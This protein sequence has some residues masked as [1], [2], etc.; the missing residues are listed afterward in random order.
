MLQVPFR[1]FITATF[2]GIIPASFIYSSIGNSLAKVIDKPEFQDNIILDPTIILAL[3]GLGALAL[4]PPI[5]QKLKK[6][7]L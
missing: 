6:K 2:I 7:K 3:F 1:I 4:L 5:Y